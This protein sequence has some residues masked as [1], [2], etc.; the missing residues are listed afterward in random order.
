M[1]VLAFLQNQW[2]RNPQRVQEKIALYGEEY[3]CKFVA[4]AL[5]AGC[6]TGRRLRQGLGQDWC[7]AIIW[8]EASPV[9]TDRA[10]GCPPPDREHIRA[11]IKAHRPH[12]VLC[13][14]KPAQPVVC[15]ECESACI[16]LLTASHPAARHN[17]VMGELRNLRARL[18]EMTGLL[19][20]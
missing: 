11:A 8:E 13:L 3:R 16:R 17:G 20:A 1:I 19:I 7:D 15:A 4:Y 5:F 10:S 6:L 18:D 9:I 2:F 14:S 12:V